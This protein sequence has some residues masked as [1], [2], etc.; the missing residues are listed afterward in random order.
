MS[1]I[2]L[3]GDF[4]IFYLRYNFWKPFIYIIFFLS[5]KNHCVLNVRFLKFITLEFW[6]SDL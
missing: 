1:D 4:E 2:K 5:R 6:Y 3:I